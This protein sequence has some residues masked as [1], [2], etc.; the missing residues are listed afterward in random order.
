MGRHERAE[1][2]APEI[3]DAVTDPS[4]A[5][6]GDRKNYEVV[7]AD[8][9][10]IGGG[11]AD[12][13]GPTFVAVMLEA[14]TNN[15]ERPIARLVFAADAKQARF[16][17]EQLLHHANAVDDRQPPAVTPPAGTQEGE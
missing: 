16:L 17:A 11:G 13:T 3:I 5:D 2:D 14:L 15:E 9:C 8:N 4:T 10:V 6:F 7:F 12:D 1:M